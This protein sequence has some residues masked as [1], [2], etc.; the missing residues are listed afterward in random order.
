VQGNGNNHGPIH[1]DPYPNTDSPGQ[2]AECSA[3][4]EPYSP[5]QYVIGNPSVNVGTKTET[6]TRSGG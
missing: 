6:T 2:R 5:Y 4:N 3:G 1:V